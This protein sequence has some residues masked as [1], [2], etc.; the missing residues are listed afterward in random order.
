MNTGALALRHRVED[1]VLAG[2]MAIA[3]IVPPRTLRA[4]GRAAADVA[5]VL[6]RRHRRVT[7]DN[8]EAAYG[9]ELDERARRALA[10]RSWRHLGGVLFETLSFPTLTGESLIRD[11]VVVGA[12]HYAVARA[13]GR[14]VLFVTGH[15][16]NWE[17]AAIAH[18][19]VSGRPLAVIARP[20]DNPR[21]ERRLA[22]LR[23]VSGNTVIP[24]RNASRA[25]VKVL[26]EGGDI[27]ILIDQDA[28][29]SGVFVPFFGLPASTTPIVAS[30]ALRTG[31]AILPA[32]CE[33]L[34]GGGHLV[35][36][37]PE[38][39]YEP[40]GEPERDIVA[41]T[42]RCTEALERRIR[43]CPEMWLWAHR[44]WKTRPGAN[45][46]YTEGSSPETR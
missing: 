13:R 32:F 45:P 23:A 39:E 11:V 22:A 25:I 44:R 43:T 40:T 35:T 7:L 20:L 15:Y 16:G 17:L 26:R 37:A 46:G 27:G 18:G 6:D 42:A 3:R 21:L 19:F 29:K 1:A 38:I 36:Y 28:R 31:A 12:E 5:Y 9:S 41:L 8:L 2:A 10:R 4:A 14:G 34:A 33:P 30:L 24:K